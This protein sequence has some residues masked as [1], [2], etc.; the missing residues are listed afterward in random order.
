M[1]NNFF[2]TQLIFDVY[3]DI[4]FKLNRLNLFSVK[5]STFAIAFIYSRMNNIIYLYGLDCRTHIIYCRLGNELNRVG[6]K[7]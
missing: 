3:F 4:K 5:L 1:I 7:F 2:L 6:N